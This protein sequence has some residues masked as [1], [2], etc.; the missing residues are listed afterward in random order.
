M[1]E[2]KSTSSNQSTSNGHSS[3]Y[4]RRP[5]HQPSER[6]REQ[7][8]NA[9]RKFRSKKQQKKEQ[10]QCNGLLDSPVSTPTDYSHA[11]FTAQAFN[12]TSSPEA[13][14]MR[15]DSLESPTRSFHSGG[16]YF[17]MSQDE[18]DNALL[19]TWAQ[20]NNVTDHSTCE[21]VFGQVCAS[22]SS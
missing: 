21:Q 1:S 15:L 14:S 13:Q 18:V 10:D 19:D 4:D 20:M 2:G 5:Y 12:I 3:G 7:N 9:Q 17:G 11:T 22:H 8:R 16:S 6:R